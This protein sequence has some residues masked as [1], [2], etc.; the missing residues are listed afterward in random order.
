MFGQIIVLSSVAAAAGASAERI[1]ITGLI[2]QMRILLR[3]KFQDSACGERQVP[4]C[5]A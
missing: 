5:A 1:D 4:D 2:L 3:L